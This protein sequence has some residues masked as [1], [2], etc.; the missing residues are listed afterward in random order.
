MSLVTD[1]FLSAQI[2]LVA[3]TA[4]NLIDSSARKAP[5]LD[6]RMLKIS[7][8]ISSRMAQWAE[9]SRYSP[10]SIATS[11]VFTTQLFSRKMQAGT[12]S[13]SSVMALR[14]ISHTGYVLTLGALSGETKASSRSSRVF[15]RSTSGWTAAKLI[16]EQSII[17]IDSKLSKSVVNKGFDRKVSQWGA[18]RIIIY[19]VKQGVSNNESTLI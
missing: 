1:L 15:A 16:S 9:F 2:C 5:S 6:L 3:L 7:R 18:L 10:T 14:M 11:Q 17:L 19:L 8:L 4:P 13:R 12:Q